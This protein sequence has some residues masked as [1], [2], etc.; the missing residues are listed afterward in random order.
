[1]LTAQILDHPD[2][3][4]AIWPSFSDLRSAAH[5]TKPARLRLVI[6]AMVS[7]ARIVF[8]ACFL[9]AR[10]APLPSSHIHAETGKTL[11]EWIQ[12]LLRHASATLHSRWRWTHD[13]C[14]YLH[15]QLSELASPSPWAPVKISELPFSCRPFPWHESCR[16]FPAAMCAFLHSLRV[17]APWEHALD[18]IAGL[19]EGHLSSDG[20]IF[21][22]PALRETCILDMRMIELAKPGDPDALTLFFTTRRMVAIASSH[23]LR[24]RP[25]P[26]PSACLIV[27]DRGT[28]FPSRF[29]PP[30]F[31]LTKRP[32]RDIMSVYNAAPAWHRRLGPLD[33]TTATIV[34]GK[35][36]M[37]K[38][39]F[40]FRPSA[41]KNHASW[42]QNEAAKIALG[43]KFATWVWQGIV[44][45]VPRNCPPP[46]FIEPLG[47]VDKAT[48]PWWRLI[49]DA[50]LSNEFHDPWG[51]W[52]FSA[53]QLAALL[54]HCDIMFAEDLEDA[55]HLSIFS[56]CTGKPF[57]SWTFAVDE[58]NGVPHIVQ[59]WR[60]VMG[61]DP[62]SCLG[63]CD[64]AMS[65]FSF[66][67]FIGRFAAAHFGQRNAGSPLNVL[68]RCI[69][70]FLSRRGP[71]NASKL[72]T[73]RL[74]EITVEKI[75]PAPP[76]PRRGLGPEALLSV[77]WVDDA[78]YVTKTPPHLPCVGLL[79]GC[80]VCS[81]SCKAARRSQSGWHCLAHELGLG[82]S[83]EK[84]Q[85]PSQRITYTG[86]VVDTFHRTISIPPEKKSRLVKFLE[87]FFECRVSSGTDLASLRGR[88][89]HY[90]AC[91]PYVQPFVALFSSVLETED[92]PI[93]ARVVPIPPAVNEAALFIRDVIEEFAIKGRP[94]WPL[95]SS[96]LHASF[97][98]NETGAA[99]IAV[100]TW[101][102]SLHGWGMVLRWWNNKDGVV[103]IGTLPDSADMQHQVR[104][105][106]LAGVLALEAA[107]RVVDLTESTVILRNDAVG[108][109]TALRK[110]SFASTFLQQCAIR[111]C[112]LQRR[113]RCN[114]LLLHAPG[115][116]LVDEGVDD[117]SRRGAL[118]VAGPASSSKVRER[119]LRLANACGWK[120]TIDAFASEFNSI[121]PRFFARY[122]EPSAEAENAFT[123][124]DWAYSACP[125]CGRVHRETLFAY[126]PPA[127]LNPFIAKARADGTRAIVVTPLAV[128]APFWNKL[129]RSSV[130][131]NEEGYIRVR[132]QHAPPGS[133]VHGE[134]AIFAVDF[135]PF[136]SRKR[137]SL[138][139]P[140]CGKESLLRGRPLLGSLADQAER[141]RIHAEIMKL[142][143]TLRPC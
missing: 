66:D 8:G 81:K 44:E 72:N 75:P 138:C 87:P 71:A 129:L 25:L 89:Q 107:A 102:A 7:E 119:S 78:V 36:Q 117:Y 128:S 14:Q 70:R 101:D 45:I 59:R 130:T 9:L 2:C 61:C 142:G 40:A 30:Y 103:I 1:M 143:D 35:L 67:G 112:H 18:L 68:M 13:Q 91:L 140:P 105:E 95:V 51:V 19:S 60:L 100:V 125:A 88:V 52:Y 37:P 27:S 93:S 23:S 3:V 54:D 46:L 34:S 113:L 84:R 90:S 50:R 4:A 135:A 124:P 20:K 123:V 57:W 109:L 56:G 77:V 126:P 110:G 12:S 79:A 97:I 98:A 48:D 120:I 94:L 15:A 137:D 49:L 85:F 41:R 43:P 82:L 16:P 33:A 55:Y 136:S 64:K 28:T 80:P 47:A 86:I 131:P 6:S 92:E 63:L 139:V 118:E 62:H 106:T 114:T 134:L 53:A 132:R 116:V 5:A 58:R 122:A 83:H 24:P 127:L 73:K 22:T 26:T 96:T 17:G 74:R 11:H 141:S 29:L 115:R 32:A 121:L 99:H 42:E 69:Q 104:R 31:K 108:A 10:A 65:G 38:P 133:D 76:P 111:S 39:R 21:V